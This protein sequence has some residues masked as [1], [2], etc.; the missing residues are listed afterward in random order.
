MNANHRDNADLVSLPVAVAIAIARLKQN[1]GFRTAELHKDF[2][3]NLH[4]C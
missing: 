3:W 2:L 4:L 1:G